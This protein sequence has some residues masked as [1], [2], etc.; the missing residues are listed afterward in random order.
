MKS[1]QQ[2]GPGWQRRTT[3]L[4]WP[5]WEHILQTLTWSQ[6]RFPQGPQWSQ[7]PQT[8]TQTPKLHQCHELGHGFWQQLK[9]RYYHDLGLQS[10]SAHSSLP[11]PLQICLTPQQWIIL[12]LFLSHFLNLYSLTGVCQVNSWLISSCPKPRNELSHYPCYGYIKMPLTKY[13]MPSW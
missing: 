12:P 10:L 5:L 3:I 9:L 4:A 1:R 8:L 7:E 6:V 11:L 2:N 13:N